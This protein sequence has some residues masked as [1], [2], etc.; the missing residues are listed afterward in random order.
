MVACRILR[1]QFLALGPVPLDR[2]RRDVQ[3]GFCLNSIGRKMRFL[4]QKQD[5]AYLSNK[6][7][8]CFSEKIDQNMNV[9]NLTTDYALLC[10]T[11]LVSKIYGRI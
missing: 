9:E 4:D 8:R 1:N 11:L 7:G 5:F 2:A 10:G 6:V 3:F